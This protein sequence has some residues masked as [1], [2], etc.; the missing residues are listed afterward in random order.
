[1]KI[2]VKKLWS[3][4]NVFQ[5]EYAFLSL[6]IFNNSFQIEFDLLMSDVFYIS[7]CLYLHDGWNN[8][9]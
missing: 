6:Y 7:F 1:M 3:N 5:N 4:D 2:C 9:N 8:K